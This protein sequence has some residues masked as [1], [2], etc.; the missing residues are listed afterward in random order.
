MIRMGVM[1]LNKSEGMKA[2]MVR[3]GLANNDETYVSIVNNMMPGMPASQDI[4]NVYLTQ[5]SLF[6]IQMKK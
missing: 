3:S 6:E 5:E 2:C 4:F 1:T